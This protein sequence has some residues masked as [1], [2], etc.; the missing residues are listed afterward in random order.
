MK[1]TAV[2]IFIILLAQKIY[3]DPY[4]ESA[5]RQ[6][7]FKN[8]DKARELFLESAENHNNGNSYFFLGEIEKLEENYDKALYYYEKAVQEQEIEKNYLRN[9]YWNLIIIYEQRGK[10][11][12]VIKTCKQMWER[13]RYEGAKKRIEDTID[14]FLWTDNEEAAELYREGLI[15][16]DSGDPEGAEQHFN[17]ALYISS[18][19]LAPRVELGLAAY[20]SGDLRRA[21]YYLNS[22]ASAIP[23]YSDIHLV[24]GDI[25]MKM[26]NWRRAVYHLNLVFEFGLLDRNTEFTALLRRASS[27]HKLRRFDEAVEDIERALEIN[28]RSLAGIILL[29]SI[30]LDRNNKEEALANLRQAERIDSRNPFVLLNMG[31]ILLDKE[32]S[33]YVDY[34]QRLFNSRKQD[35]S[36]S[37]RQVRAYTAL[38]EHYYEYQNYRKALDIRAAIP[39]SRRDDHLNRITAYSHYHL[40][41]YDN[42]LSFFQMIRLRNED[43]L[44]YAKAHYMNGS[45]DKAKNHLSA[46]FHNRELIDAAENDRDLSKVVAEIRREREATRTPA[47]APVQ[48]PVIKPD[49]PAAPDEHEKEKAPDMAEDSDISGEE[50]DVEPDRESDI[51]S[52]KETP[53][54]TGEDMENPDEGPD[55]E[56]DG[57]NGLFPE[58]IDYD[59]YLFQ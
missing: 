11:N 54:E 50:A 24:M 48:R 44:I 33:G 49:P 14:R 59:N 8:F 39:V 51:H 16:Q 46:R 47:P 32:D 23:F 9:A 52:G 5:R 36:P 6:Y 3:A 27:L 20:R 18:S 22:V 55:T 15:L 10:T 53:G 25:A 21:A 34:F 31:E 7:I 4:Y 42:A 30:N 28:P 38:V 40:K 19:F 29:A 56:A 35:E 17:E 13:L 37:G 2:L 57:D 58:E 41:E 12:E 1:K 45:P 43:H 26:R